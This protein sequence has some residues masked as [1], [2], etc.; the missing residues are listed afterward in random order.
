M[1]PVLM[2]TKATLCVQIASK[3]RSMISFDLKSSVQPAT[4]VPTIAA[5]AT[6]PLLHVI[7]CMTHLSAVAGLAHCDG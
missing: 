1:S 4:L 6:K 2:L 7:I 5:V 3:R